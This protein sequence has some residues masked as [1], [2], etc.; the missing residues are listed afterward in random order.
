MLVTSLLISSNHP[1]LSPLLHFAVPLLFANRQI[2]M[3]LCLRFISF[4]DN[5]EFFSRLGLDG[6]SHNVRNEVVGGRLN[7]RSAISS[8]RHLT[9]IGI[10]AKVLEQSFA[11]ILKLNLGELLQFIFD[12]VNLVVKLIDL[13]GNILLV[14]LAA[15]D[16]FRD[17]DKLLG[18]GQRR[19]ESEPRVLHCHHLDGLLLVTCLHG[20]CSKYGEGL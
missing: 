17:K 7:R 10:L 9:I 14:E 18:V 6:L 3:F 16:D 20:V 4:I 5:F 1:L 12:L 13:V 8:L 11:E 2:L 19:E 15:L